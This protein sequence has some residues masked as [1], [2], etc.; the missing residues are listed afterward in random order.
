MKGK[1]KTK[2]QLNATQRKTNKKIERQKTK[3]KKQKFVLYKCAKNKKAASCITCPVSMKICLYCCNIK[4]LQISFLVIS[5]LL[6]RKP[7]LKGGTCTN[8]VFQPLNQD[9]SVH[10]LF[11]L[12]RIQVARLMTLVIAFV[13][14]KS[15]IR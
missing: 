4:M 12:Q 13:I 9:S 6:V 3:N 14:E 8:S 7:V 5:L 1:E 15:S 11:D 2:T 10:S